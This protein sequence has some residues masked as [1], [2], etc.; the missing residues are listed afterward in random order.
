MNAAQLAGL[1]AAFKTLQPEIREWLTSDEAAAATRLVA[2]RLILSRA[3]ET[4]LP[5]LILRLVAQDIPP[6]SFKAEVAQALSVTPDIAEQAIAGIAEG[7][8]APVAQGLRF[9]GID[10]SLLGFDA[11]PIPTATPQTPEPMPAR[12]MDFP[13][14]EPAPFPA[15]VS[16][17]EP[18]PPAPAAPAPQIPSITPFIIH[19]EPKAA[20][21]AAPKPSFSFAPQAPARAAESGPAP[22]VMIERVVHYTNL[23]SSLTEPSRVRTERR[24][25]PRAP[26]SRWF[27]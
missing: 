11:P 7:V 14:P 5:I 25:P 10:I 19:A 1:Y 2:E 17:P 18:A 4:Q 16:A 9:A 21:A 20:R 12:T 22:K 6:E 24:E 23:R 26:E 3:Q 8:L 13:A 15:E 27:S